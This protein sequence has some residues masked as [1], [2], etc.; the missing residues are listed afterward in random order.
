MHHDNADESANVGD[1]GSDGIAISVA[2]CVAHTQSVCGA[3][4]VADYRTY[5]GS[6]CCTKH[7]TLCGAVEHR[8]GYDFNY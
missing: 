5:V 6:F 1:E 2:V 8:R 7:G 4:S 3:N